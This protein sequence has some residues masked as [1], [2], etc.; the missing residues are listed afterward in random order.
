MTKLQS[1]KNLSEVNLM[2]NE[3]FDEMQW[4]LADIITEIY[5]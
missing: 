1:L 2:P 3:Y 5:G 4:N